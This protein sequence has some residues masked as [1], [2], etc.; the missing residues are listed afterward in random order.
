M[1]AMLPKHAVVLLAHAHP[2]YFRSQELLVLVSLKV[3]HVMPI[4]TDVMEMANVST[5]SNL[6]IQ[7]VA[8]L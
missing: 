3:G 5:S 8:L 2:T 6:V 4:L 1:A 7:F